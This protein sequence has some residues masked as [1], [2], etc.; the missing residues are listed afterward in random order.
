MRDLDYIDPRAYHWG[1]V[2]RRVDGT[3]AFLVPGIKRVF[4][5]F[6]EGLDP[7]TPA[8]GPDA[9]PTRLDCNDVG[10]ASHHPEV[11]G[12]NIFALSAG[13]G[14]CVIHLI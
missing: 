13:Q 10:S 4:F 8:D 3:D 12:H 9:L 2:L 5:R 6:A 1:F 14:Q 7:G 11:A